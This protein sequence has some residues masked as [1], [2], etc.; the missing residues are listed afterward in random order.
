LRV[1]VY[2]RRPSLTAFFLFLFKNRFELICW[3]YASYYENAVLAFFRWLG[4][5]R[6]VIK[7]DSFSPPPPKSLRNRLSR[8]LFYRW[9]E[10][11]ADVLL[12]ETPAVAERSYRLG[13]AA[14]TRLFPNGVPVGEWKR[15][16]PLLTE[17]GAP[18]PGPYL[19]FTGRIC[20]PKGVDLLIESF[21][22]IADRCPDWSLQVVGPVWDEAYAR[23]CRDRVKALGLEKRVEFRPAQFGLE[24]WR[25]YAH[26]GIFVLP[27]REEGLANRLTEAMYYRL[28]VVAFDIRQTGWLVNADSGRLVAPEDVQGLGDACWELIQTGERRQQRG[29][30]ARARVEQELDDG[31]L[32]A[33][34]LNRLAELLKGRN[35]NGTPNSSV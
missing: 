19:L 25:W 31:V 7:F 3:S 13:H 11:Q 29:A 8:Q 30:A 10:R 12:A 33:G 28:P 27:S 18:V 15:L 4:R 5:F 16:E 9:P 17:K 2:G 22:R 26:A 21:G 23:A 24:L 34:L 20:A 32:T 14:K 6:L 35:E 1:A